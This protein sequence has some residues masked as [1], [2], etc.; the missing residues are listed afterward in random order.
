M[1]TRSIANKS[2]YTISIMRYVAKLT[3]IALLVFAHSANAQ[4]EPDPSKILNAEFR[5]CVVEGFVMDEGYAVI[6][7]LDVELAGER[8]YRAR[9][10]MKGRFQF[11]NVVEGV[12]ELRAV[13]P[14][15][16]KAHKMRR[17]KVEP[18]RGQKEQHIDLILRPTGEVIDP[19]HP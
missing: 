19:Q 11:D 9:S 17:L 2:E 7:G 8:T 14:L 15:W 4:R 5:V 3:L 6:V 16:K 13:S 10:D 18:S 1:V 12:Y